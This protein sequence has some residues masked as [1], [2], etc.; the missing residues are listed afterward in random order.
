MHSFMAFCKRKF[1][2]LSPLAMLMLLILIMCVFFIRPF[3]VLNRHQWSG[4]TVSHLNSFTLVFRLLLLIVICLHFT[5][6]SL[7]FICFYILMI[8]L[9][10]GIVHLLLLT[11]FQDLGL[12]FDLKD[13][14]PLKYFLGLQI[15]YTSQG[16]FVH[17]S[18]YALDLLPSSICWIASHVSPL[19]PPQCMLTLKSVLYL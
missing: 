1:S 9:S 17:Q 5:M 19:V 2:C 6:I 15:E 14:G 4:L 11:L 12:L 3:M 13:L 18:K 16:F 10:L 8:S 7:W